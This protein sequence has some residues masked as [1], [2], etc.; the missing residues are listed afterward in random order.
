MSRKSGFDSTPCDRQP[1]QQCEQLAAESDFLAPFS[2]G[3]GGQS[4]FELRRDVVC[5]IKS[6]Y[7]IDD[8]NLPHNASALL[9]F[10][11]DPI[12]RFHPTAASA[13]QRCFGRVDKYRPFHQ[14]TRFMQRR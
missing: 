2:G 8:E 13:V 14:I 10:L 4:S 7:R 5:G 1:P 6:G 11:G 9:V 12:P 3:N